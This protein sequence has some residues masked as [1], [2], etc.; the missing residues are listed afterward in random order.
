MKPSN[1][2]FNTYY[3]TKACE[4]LGLSYKIFDHNSNFVQVNNDPTLTFVNYRTPFNNE[5]V[6]KI[7]LDKEFSYKLLNSIISMPKT[8]G[9]FKPN[10]S[11]QNRVYRKYKT[12]EE[13]I[14]KINQEFTYPLIIKRNNGKQGRHVYL[15]K[16]QTEAIS[17]LS[18]IFNNRIKH[19][20]FVALAQEYLEIK[21]EFRVVIFNKKIELI[22]QKVSPDK[23]FDFKLISP[24]HRPEA[25]ALLITDKEIK[26]ELQQFINPIFKKLDIGFG[27]LDVVKTKN[28]KL[29]LLELNSQPG[30][31]HFLKNND[32]EIIIKLYQKMLLK[33]LSN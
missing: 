25:E 12:Q 22:Y 6:S 1:T 28:N 33:K 32:E 14:E 5:V 9:F 21:T 19:N 23:P 18:K 31:S 27:G 17:A 15:V 20:D 29:W 16:N 3:L 13:I 8:L 11:P 24:L 30:F 2:T 10:C 4:K 7:C 26:K